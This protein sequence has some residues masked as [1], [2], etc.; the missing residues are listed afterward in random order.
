[1]VGP[2]FFAHGANYHARLLVGADRDPPGVAL[3][4]LCCGGSPLIIYATKDR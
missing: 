3:W 1:M 4:E 2:L